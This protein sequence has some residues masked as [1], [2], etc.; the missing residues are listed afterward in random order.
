MLH[1]KRTL[2]PFA[3]EHR[4]RRFFSQFIIAHQPYDFTR[5]ALVTLKIAMKT[6]NK[7]NSQL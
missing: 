2:N 3:D 1:F 6:N 5:V 7:K 4:F